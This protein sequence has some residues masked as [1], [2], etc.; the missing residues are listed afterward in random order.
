MPDARPLPDRP[1]LAP[2]APVLRRGPASRQVGLD[3]RTAVVL[4]GPGVPALLDRLDGQTRLRTLRTLAA[5]DGMSAADVDAVLRALQAAGLL[6][7]GAAAD[8]TSTNQAGTEPSRVRVVGLGPLGQQVT[9]LLLAAGLPVVAARLDR[10]PPESARGRPS[11]ATP[12]GLALPDAVPVPAPSRGR[13]S[14]VNHWSKPDDARVALTV[15]A[16]DTVEPDRTVTEWLVRE[17]QPHLVLRLA[18]TAATVGPLVLPG[19]TPC[20]RCTDLTR[21]DLDPA[22]P[23]LLAQL[24]TLRLPTPPA[25]LAWAAATAVVQVMARLQHQLPEVAGATLELDA[26]DHR[27][28]WRAWPLHTGCG[29]AW[30]ATTEWGP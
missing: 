10:P 19:R 25:L 28:R 29:C 21:R 11:P 7:D 9:A 30:A 12:P 3:P 22:W 15:V 26:R 17:D 18:G 5:G 27:S 1:A 2:H 20:L 8:P 14:L 24:T 13:L 16:P 4:S 6:L 23:T